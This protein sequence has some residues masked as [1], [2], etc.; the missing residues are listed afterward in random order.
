MLRTS[1]SRNY[2]GYASPVFDGILDKL[3][4]EAA[5]DKRDALARQAEEQLFTDAPV[6][7]LLSPDW[8]V[9]LS[10]RLASYQPWGSDYHVLRAD[11]GEKP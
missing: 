4:G 9:G 5:P 6:S 7:F 8:Y 11:I 3:A 10:Q 2:S 1:A